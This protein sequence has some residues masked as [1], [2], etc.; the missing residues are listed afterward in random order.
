MRPH[1]LEDVPA[2]TLDMACN[3]FGRLVGISCLDVAR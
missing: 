1:M 3:E 2:G